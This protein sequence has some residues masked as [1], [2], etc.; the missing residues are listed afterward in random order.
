M[1]TTVDRQN[2]SVDKDSVLTCEKCDHFRDIIW[3]G[4]P[5]D[6][7]AFPKRRHYFFTLLNIGSGLG[8]S[9]TRRHGVDPP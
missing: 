6:W 9:E 4:G 3:C 7:E 8:R 2:H 5:A 1:E